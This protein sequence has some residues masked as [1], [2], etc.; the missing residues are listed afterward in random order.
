MLRRQSRALVP[1]P[2]LS[3]AG[4]CVTTKTDVRS[5]REW[6]AVTSELRSLDY[7]RCSSGSTTSWL[8]G[9]FS[10]TGG[11]DWHL[12]NPELDMPNDAIGVGAFSFT[13]HEGT[14]PKTTSS[15]SGSMLGL[16]P[17]HNHHTKLEGAANGEIV[18]GGIEFGTAGDIQV[19]GSIY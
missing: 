15:A 6:P 9:P 14:P 8:V 17:L 4:A 5:S 1:E 3:E 13:F 7:V 10:T 12:L 11:Y 18:E 19:R 2:A 16:P